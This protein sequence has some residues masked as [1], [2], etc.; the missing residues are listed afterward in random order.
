MLLRNIAYAIDPQYAKKQE[1]I[2]G[3]LKPIKEGNATI[4][5]QD[6]TKEARKIVYIPQTYLNRTIDDP[7]KTTAIDSI[8]ADVLLQEPEIS[9]A[10]EELQN[11]LN[12][13]KKKVLNTTMEWV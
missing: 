7:E 10:Y 6:G 8:I 5:W 9:K 11:T 12:L 13:I 3:N 1:A 4:L 2:V